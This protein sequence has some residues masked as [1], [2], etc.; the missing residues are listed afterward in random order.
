MEK[1]VCTSSMS[2]GNAKV[3][4]SG[5]QISRRQSQYRYGKLTWF[6]TR[7]FYVRI[8][9]FAVPD[10]FIPECLTLSHVPVN[11][12]SLLEINGSK[13][14]SLSEG[15]SSLLRRNR[16]DRRTDEAT[17]VSTDC[18]KLTGNVKFEVMYKEDVIISGI[19]EMSNS[20]GVSEESKSSNNNDTRRWSLDCDV[21][22]SPGLEFLKGGKT[23]RGVSETI[24]PT[25]EVYV[26]GC[27]SGS[28]IILTKTL[29]LKKNSKIGT[30]NSIP[31]SDGASQEPFEPGLIQ[32]KRYTF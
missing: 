7:V 31:E 16:A 6:D 27:V 2:N 10:D 13:C 32:V 23:G 28:P 11:P 19:L 14:S 8:S 1:S 3:A 25:I 22:K 29:R 20:N 21:V 24:S 18:I 12:D 9:N 30:L 4:D 17:F 15:E 26:A 5:L